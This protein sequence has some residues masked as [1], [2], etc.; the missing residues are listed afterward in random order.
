[1]RIRNLTVLMAS[2]VVVATLSACGSASDDADPGAPIAQVDELA[3]HG[4]EPCPAAL[5]LDDDGAFGGSDPASE[6][7]SIPEADEAWVCQYDVK[8]SEAEPDHRMMSSWMRAGE[9]APV[10]GAALADL[11]TAL[12]ALA[13]ASPNQACTMDL[14]PRFL[15]VVSTDGDLTG[16]LVDD[17]GCRDVRLTGDPYEVPAGAE[18]QDGIVGGILTGGTEVLQAVGVGRV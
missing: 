6:A 9:P 4:G 17:Y 11:Q 13:P 18:G 3:D 10:E 7:P 14:G 5:P 1:M 8:E 12:A 2:G 16:V 15:V